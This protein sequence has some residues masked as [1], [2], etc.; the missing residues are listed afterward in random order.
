MPSPPARPRAF[1]EDICRGDSR[2]VRMAA[3]AAV[4]AKEVSTT[5]TRTNV[6]SAWGV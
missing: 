6:R 3:S 2:A 1:E 4:G 5:A